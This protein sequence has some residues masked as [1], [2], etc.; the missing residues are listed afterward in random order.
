[1]THSQP[2][3]WV[4]NKHKTTSGDAPAINGSTPNKYY[5]YYENDYR[6]QAIFVFDYASREGVLYHG[7]AGWERT[8]K[9]VDGLVPEL[10]LSQHEEMWLQACWNAATSFEEK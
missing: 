6:E 8:Y 7:D 9:V 10:I 1:M 4:P 2:L 3:F 5:G